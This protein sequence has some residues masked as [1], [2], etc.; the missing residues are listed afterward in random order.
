MSVYHRPV[1]PPAQYSADGRTPEARKRT[2]LEPAIRRE[3]LLRAAAWAFARKGY[4]NASITDIIQRAGVARGTFYLYFDSKEQVFLAIVETFH[5][6]IRHALA[7]AAELPDIGTDARALLVT[8]FTQWLEFFAAHR[9][10][11]R[12]IVREASSIDPR[13]EKGYAA[14][15]ASAVAFLAG[16]T[17]HLQDLGLVRATVS[18][19]LAAHLQLGMLDEVL[20]AFVL[21]DAD[22]DI[23]G[24][25]EQMVDMQW[26]GLR[27]D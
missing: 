10:V 2:V 18:P 11:A 20:T 26:N 13:F 25:V 12:V 24:L 22:A 16:R 6:R 3:Q 27:P 21:E 7:S 4:R 5:G 14:L 19:D 15:R 23:P 8:R 9:D 1:A 17:R